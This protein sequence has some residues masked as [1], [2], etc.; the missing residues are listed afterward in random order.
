MKINYDAILSC[1]YFIRILL[2][3]KKQL[4]VHI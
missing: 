2:K 3:K 4:Y 1:K